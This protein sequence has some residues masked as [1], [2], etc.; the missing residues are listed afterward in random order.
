MALFFFAHISLQSML[1]VTPKPENTLKRLQYGYKKNGMKKN[2]A[3]SLNRVHI[4]YAQFANI[5]LFMSN[6]ADVITQPK[7][8]H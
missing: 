7:S 1:G 6:F 8:I 2:V 4:E 5:Q 3:Q